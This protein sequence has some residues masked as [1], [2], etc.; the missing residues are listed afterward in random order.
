MAYCAGGLDEAIQCFMQLSQ[1]AKPFG[2][3][4]QYH[5]PIEALIA[6]L[7]M[8][9]LNGNTRCN[10]RPSQLHV[11]MTTMSVVPGFSGRDLK[12]FVAS[13][14]GV[15]IQLST[16]TKSIAGMGMQRD[17]SSSLSQ[18]GPAFI[19]RSNAKERP[20]WACSAQDIIHGRCCC[21]DGV[22]VN[23][24]AGTP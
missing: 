8:P 7:E 24:R 21:D 3:I 9:L 5:R 18:S 19:A 2:T 14:H 12:C 20:R 13:R 16:R 17:A 4:A 23:R 10:T 22:K 15:K 6:L 1:N 11:F